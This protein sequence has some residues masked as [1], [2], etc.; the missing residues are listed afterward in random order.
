M[1]FSA[2]ERFSSTAALTPSTPSTCLSM[3]LSSNSLPTLL[4]DV[5]RTSPHFLSTFAVITCQEARV[6]KGAVWGAV[7]DAVK[8]AVK[9]G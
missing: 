6:P 4:S 2:T 5:G 8:N 1:I 3:R 9:G 7:K